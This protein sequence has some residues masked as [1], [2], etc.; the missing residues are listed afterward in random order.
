VGRD[1][2]LDLHNAGL[3]IKRQNQEKSAD[4]LSEADERKPLHVVRILD[5]L[6]TINQVVR[7]R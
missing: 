4:A 2:A 5:N 6:N 1:D 3:L 7:V